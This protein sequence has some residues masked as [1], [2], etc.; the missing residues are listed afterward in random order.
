MVHPFTPTARMMISDEKRPAPAVASVEPGSDLTLTCAVRAFPPPGEFT[1]FRG[2]G[3]ILAGGGGDGGTARKSRF[4]ISTRRRTQT[5]VDSSLRVRNVTS[6]D[7]GR[8]SCLSGS[9]SAFVWVRVGL[10]STG[11]CVDRGPE[12]LP[13]LD[14]AMVVRQ[15][16]CGNR[17]YARLCC[18]SCSRAGFDPPDSGG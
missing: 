8:Y 6:V 17:H 2:S 12:V 15:D 5:V 13:G 1:W 11:R 9:A 10:G 18:E 3:E 4:S 7:T 14:C 16:Y